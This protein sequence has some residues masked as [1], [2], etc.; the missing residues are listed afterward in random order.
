MLTDT[1]LRALRPRTSLYRIAD[2]NGL[3]IEVTPAGSKLWRYRF[4]FNGKASMATLGEY[5][6]VSLV[7]ARRRRDEARA[8]LGAGVS[9]VTAARARRTAQA[10]RA[11]N[12]FAAVAAELLAQRAK[13]LSAG[14]VKREQRLIEQDLV[15]RIGSVPVA[16]V[17][18]KALLAALR[19]IEQRGA[20]ET[21]HRA[22]SLAS[23][24]FRYAIATGR[25]ERNPAADLIGALPSPSSGHFA[26]VTDP[27]AVA[28]MLRSIHAYQGTAIVAAALKLAPLV[29]VRPGELRSMRWADV[30]LKAGEWRFTASKTG[31]PHIVPLSSQAVAVLQ[32]L[33][34]LT[35]SG[36]FAFPSIRSIRRPMSENTLNAAL[37]TLGYDGK[38]MTGHGFRAMARTILDEV[39]GF[40][41]DFIEH[42]LA[43]AVRDPLGRA[44]NRTAH[45]VE[46]RKM[47][48]SWADY[49]DK[50][51]EGDIKVVPLWRKR[52]SAAGR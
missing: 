50:L 43:H 10:E 31:T 39:L 5:P 22:R 36:E 11:S 6:I 3:C 14:S 52:A 38:T 48:Q 29:F 21:A 2:A 8:T 24:I 32:E 19:K 46:R 17:E 40:R 45:L 15:P 13:T 51:R 1:K 33:H 44:Y 27:D 26:S 30:D 20:V 4:R 12:T 35:N 23:Q 18:P 9:P 16:D 37:R 49:L 42:Q 47:M 25:A 41:P 28:P 34:P 7:D